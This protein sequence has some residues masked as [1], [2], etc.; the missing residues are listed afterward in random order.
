MIALTMPP[1][2]P[3]VWTTSPAR[4]E[5][6]RRRLDERHRDLSGEAKTRAAR[7]RGSR[8]ART[9]SELLALRADFLAALG[10]LSAFEA[11]SLTLAGCRYELQI[12]AYADDLSRDYFD[13]W[14]LLARRGAEPR[15]ED[16][17]GA[18]R[19]DY[20]AVQLG[21]LEGLADALMIAGRNVRLFPPPH[22][23]WLP[24]G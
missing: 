13:L 12:R 16:E 22:V 17:R 4:G 23:A 15:S 10:R 1:R 24:V 21:R 3:V 19:M 8:A 7:Y 20:F 11:A 18:E 14:Q 9:S 6:I 2:A 5:R